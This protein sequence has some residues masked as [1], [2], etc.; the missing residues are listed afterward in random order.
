MWVKWKVWRTI[1]LN[2]RKWYKINIQ[3]LKN[4]GVLITCE[5]RHPLEWRILKVSQKEI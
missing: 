2:E 5:D 4:N 3:K 1:Q